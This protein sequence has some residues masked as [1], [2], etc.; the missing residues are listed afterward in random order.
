MEAARNALTPL[1][2]ITRGWRWQGQRHV[3]TS[4]DAKA[5]KVKRLMRYGPS[6]STV[7]RHVRYN[8]IL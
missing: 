3:S 6:Q 2:P 4:C 7:D 8:I 5:L 1:N